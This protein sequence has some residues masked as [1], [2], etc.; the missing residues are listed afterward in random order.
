MQSCVMNVGKFRS[1]V[2]FDPR[3]LPFQT[4]LTCHQ[5]MFGGNGHHLSSEELNGRN[6]SRLKPQGRRC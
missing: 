1:R 6:L 2:H 4:K 5:L 3:I